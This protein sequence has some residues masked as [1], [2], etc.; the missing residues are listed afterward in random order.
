MT[1]TP[2]TK[3]LWEVDHPY[4]GPEGRINEDYASWADFFEEM[5]AADPDMNLLIRW[6]WHTPDPEGDQWGNKDHEL[7]LFFVQQ[8]KSAIAKCTVYVS[9]EDEGAV[10]EYLAKKLDYLV[11]MW[12]PVADED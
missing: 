6:D 12:S 7:L 9:P 11:M 10:R 8:R 4:Y 5:G 2:S 3:H 1:D